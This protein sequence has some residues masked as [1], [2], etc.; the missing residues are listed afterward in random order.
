MNVHMKR[1][2]PH[3]SKV[4]SESWP[5]L[6][7]NFMDAKKKARARIMACIESMMVM[8]PHVRMSC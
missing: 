2:K 5:T 3:Y 7:Q 6:W 8:V 4:V 1:A